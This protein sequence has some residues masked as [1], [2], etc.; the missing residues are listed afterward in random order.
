[1]RLASSDPP[2]TLESA[3]HRFSE[4]LASGSWP[5]TICWVTCDD[6][7]IGC[8]DFRYLVHPRKETGLHEAERMYRVGLERGLGIALTAICASNEETFAFVVVPDDDLDRQYRLMSKKLKLSRPTERR[9]TTVVRSE[10]R[11]KVLAARYAE[12]SEMLWF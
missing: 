12:R 2:E 5:R 7:L 4:F 8:R 3:T 10:L 9:L 11:W 6:I 1:M